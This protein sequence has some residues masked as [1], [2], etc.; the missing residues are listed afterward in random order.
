MNAIDFFV[1]SA[2]VL[3]WAR[4]EKWGGLHNS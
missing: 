2:S 1:M 4:T 3:S